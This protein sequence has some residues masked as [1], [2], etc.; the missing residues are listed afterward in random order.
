MAEPVAPQAS[1]ALFLGWLVCLVAAMGGCGAAGLFC[2]MFLKPS[3]FGGRD[4]QGGA[5]LAALSMLVGA[6]VALVALPL[7]TFLGLKLKAGGMAAPFWLS[8]A[9]PALAGLGAALF[10]RYA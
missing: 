6:G 3:A 1:V 8:L 9:L 10:A 7:A 5:G 2:G 4:G